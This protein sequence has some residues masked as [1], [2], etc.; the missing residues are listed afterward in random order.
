V[1]PEIAGLGLRSTDQAAGNVKQ[2]ADKVKN[3]V[4]H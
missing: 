1:L 2:A 3:A 4:K